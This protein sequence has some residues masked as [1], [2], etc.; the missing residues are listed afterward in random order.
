MTNWQVLNRFGIPAH[1]TG[2]EYLIY[3]LDTY[4]PIENGKI[5]PVCKI[6]R[7]TAAHFDTTPQKIERCIRNCANYQEANLS[8]ELTAELYGNSLRN[9][10]VS[11]GQLIFSLMRYMRRSNEA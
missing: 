8:P 2:Y 11:T 10:H 4:E 5:T 1:Y 7:E 3:I 9:G 6:Y